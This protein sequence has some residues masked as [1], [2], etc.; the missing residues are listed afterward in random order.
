MFPNRVLSPV[1]TPTSCARWGTRHLPV[2][3]HDLQ[4]ENLAR[5]SRPQTIGVE[6]HA[7]IQ[8]P[9]F[10]DERVYTT[11]CE[12]V[13]TPTLLCQVIAASN[14][15]PEEGKCRGADA[16]TG[17]ASRRNEHPN[18]NILAGG[19]MVMGEEV[20]V[21]REQALL[22]Y[23]CTPLDGDAPSSCLSHLRSKASKSDDQQRRIDK[24]SLRV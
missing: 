23:S 18:S 3:G 14:S 19:R 10:L 22:L 2:G 6:R 4:N 12:N 11:D 5:R 13:T 8:R 1:G 16:S 7:G 24:T 15:F 20:S 9:C 21:S 17:L